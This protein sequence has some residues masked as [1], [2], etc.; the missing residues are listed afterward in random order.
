MTRTQVKGN[1]I[2]D[3]TITSADL[4]D[5][6]TFVN[7]VV[8]G[9]LAVS[10]STTLNGPLEIISDSVATLEITG[11]F[12]MTGGSFI[13]NDVGSLVVTGSLLVTGEVSF[14]SG[15][16]VPMGTFNLNGSNGVTVTNSLVSSRSMIF[17][18]KQTAAHLAGI[19][20]VSSKSN[21]NFTAVSNATG[22][23][24]TVAYLIINSA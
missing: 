3:G 6:V 11:S 5:D 21:G 7:V 1:Q 22:D 9:S 24:D 15:S 19:A 8:S 16:N 17:L 2:Q 23:N 20:S 13:I 14:A 4:A 12:L 10:G 18:T